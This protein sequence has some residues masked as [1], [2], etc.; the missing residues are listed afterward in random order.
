[1]E[2]LDAYREHAER[3]YRD[4]DGKPTSEIREVKLVVKALREAYGELPAAEF[5]PLKLKAVRQGWI[6]AGLSRAECNRRANI[7]RRMFKWAAAEEL[8]PAAVY[9]AL[10]VVAGLKRGRTPARE[11]EP[12][13]PVDDAVVDATLPHL[14]RHVAGL[15]EFQRRTGCR[16]G[17]A[18]SLRRRDIDTG[19]TVW[20]YRPFRHKLAYRGKAASS[21]S[22][23]VVRNYSARSS[24]RTSTTTSTPQP[25]RWR[26]S[27]PS[28]AR[29]ERRPATRRTWTRTAG[30]T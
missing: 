2:L 21:R 5:S 10:V 7:V 16:P 26:S 23:R 8:I 30:S 20:L 17:E 3:H 29:T 13:G 25:E 15:V 12:I 1:M 24:P 4:P 6:A 11:T 22:A 18:C 9:H 27:T 28:A 14:N 19:G